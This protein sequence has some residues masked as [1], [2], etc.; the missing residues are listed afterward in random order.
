MTTS[1]VRVA[2]PRLAGSGGA[3]AG[4]IS[5]GI[6]KGKS[7]KWKSGKSGNRIAG[8]DEAGS[9]VEPAPCFLPDR[10][11][12]GDEFGAVGEGGFD[13]D[14]VDHVG[15]AFHDVGDFE[16]RGAVAHEVG[17]GAAVAGALD[18]LVGDDGD[19]FG[20]VEFDAA[21][22]AA[23]GEIGGDDDEEFFAL[24]WA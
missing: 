2:R 8:G 9:A 3:S 1:S 18:D 16:K 13:L 6:M 17:D 24:A 15:D 12:D 14:V 20:V 22:L 21:G 5:P 4:R 7:G 11:V 19:G 23:A 10:V